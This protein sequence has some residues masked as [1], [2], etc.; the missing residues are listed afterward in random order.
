MKW[1]VALFALF[2]VCAVARPVLAQPLSIYD[3]QYTTDADGVSPQDGNVV[4]CLGGVVTH[5]SFLTK[6][7]LYLQDPNRLDGWGAIAVKD[8]T[9]GSL[10]GS[11]SVGDWVSLTGVYIEEHRGNTF[12]QYGYESDNFDFQIESTGNQVPDPLPVTPADFPAPVEGPP[13][14]WLVADHAAEPYEAMW[15]TVSDVTVTATGLGKGPDN[16]N[17]HSADGDC[18]A[19]DYLNDDNFSTYHISVFHGQQ[20]Q[21]V[22]GILEQYTYDYGTQGYDYYQLMTTSSDGLLVPEPMTLVLLQAGVALL[23][24]MRARRR[25]GKRSRG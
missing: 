21:S 25:G 11:V 17:L 5:T 20:F 7:R 1:L 22:T 16:Y 24:W 14:F 18:W 15:L 9:G 4:D 2:V 13:D 23:G 10:V 3:I 12:I 6:P 8:W 19:T